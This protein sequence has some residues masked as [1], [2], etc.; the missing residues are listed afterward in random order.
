LCAPSVLRPDWNQTQLSRYS[1]SGKRARDLQ[2]HGVA[3][4]HGHVDL[5]RADADGVADGVAAHIGHRA[6]RPDQRDLGGGFVHPLRS[7][8]PGRCRRRR[9][10]QEGVE[11]LRS[12]GASGDRPRCRRPLPE[13]ATEATARQ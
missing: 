3:P 12:A 1:A 10:A 13:P 9:R 5:A 4:G 11:L 6:P 8:V 7:I 2:F